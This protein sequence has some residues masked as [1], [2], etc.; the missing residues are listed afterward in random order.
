MWDGISPY[1]C[2]FFFSVVT[3]ASMG[4]ITIRAAIVY[5]W[6]VG[7]T[8]CRKMSQSLNVLWPVQW[9]STRSTLYTGNFVNVVNC[10]HLDLEK[11]VKGLY[12]IYASHFHSDKH[13][14]ET[15][16]F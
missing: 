14:W 15:D 10:H 6:H 4:G 9:D 1:Q 3:S 13:Q 11:G 7:I 16:P 12:Y 2:S 5:I 8:A